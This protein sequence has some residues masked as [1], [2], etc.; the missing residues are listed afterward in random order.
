MWKKNAARKTISDKSN[1]V[2]I[3]KMLNKNQINP[4]LIRFGSTAIQAHDVFEK[5]SAES[6]LLTQALGHSDL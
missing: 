4:A 3:L 6:M 2:K 5:H 1:L